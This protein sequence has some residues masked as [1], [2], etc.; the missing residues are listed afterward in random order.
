M[1]LFFSL[2]AFV[3]LLVFTLV[4]IPDRIFFQWVDKLLKWMEGTH[5]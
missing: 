3:I 4:A 5:K 2:V 1:T